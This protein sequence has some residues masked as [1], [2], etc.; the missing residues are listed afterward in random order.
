[1]TVN[2]K[3]VTHKQTMDICQDQVMSDCSF[4]SHYICNTNIKNR[5]NKH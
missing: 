2:N 4:K 5:D 1:M 3:Q